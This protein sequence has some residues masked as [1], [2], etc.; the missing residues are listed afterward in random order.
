MN[1]LAETI[2]LHNGVEIP[3]IGFGTFRIPD[4]K[5]VIDAVK[6]ALTIGYRHIDTASA[7]N[8]E[9]GVGK[10][11]KESGI[12]RKE[13]FLVSKI[14]NADQGYESTLKAFEAS[15][16]RLHVD[17]LDTYL[18]HWPK[19]LSH[20]TWKAMEKLYKDGKIKAIG[21]S[22]FMIHHLEP[23]LDVCEIVPML[24]QVE[25]HPQFPQDDIREFCSKHNIAIEAWAPLMQ[26]KIFEIEL[27]KE[28][29]KK[30][31]K[32][33]AQIALRWYYQLDII[34]LPKSS[35]PERIKS[36]IEI[37]DFEISDEDM[38]KIKTLK[39]ERIG[40]HPD[41]INF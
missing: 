4:G 7:Y 9:I 26:G 18:V 5:E 11:I 32:N 28:L 29:S 12:P 20:D 41:K 40:P 6:T 16:N 8:N 24:N 2:S 39:G 37:F 17:Y 23:L 14:G 1:K 10:A 34:S 33:I 31:N 15:L 25:L 13:I 30:Y 3:K 38:E 27:M 36:N 19:P 22:N 35:N 21:I